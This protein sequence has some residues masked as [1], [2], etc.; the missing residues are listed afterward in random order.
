MDLFQWNHNVGLGLLG[1]SI[2]R[3]SVVFPVELQEGFDILAGVTAGA[4]VGS[5]PANENVLRICLGWLT[6][7]D[8]PLDGSLGH[9]HTV[10]P[11]AR[12]WSMVNRLDRQEGRRGGGSS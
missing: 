5:D 2:E 12:S 3:G 1:E 11:G 8:C 6:Y 7:R 10:P 9:S 4:S